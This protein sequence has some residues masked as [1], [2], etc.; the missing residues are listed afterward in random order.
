[1]PEIRT[2]GERLTKIRQQLLR[3]DD[4]PGNV[5][6]RQQAVAERDLPLQF[7]E[8]ELESVVLLLQCEAGVEQTFEP[9]LEV[10]RETQR[11]FVSLTCLAVAS[12]QPKNPRRHGM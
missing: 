4:G 2:G 9:G 5:A 12:F 6:V 3:L 7:S 8:D 1:M 11:L 10:D